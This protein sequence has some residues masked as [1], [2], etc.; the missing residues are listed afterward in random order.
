LR[1]RFSAVIQKLAFESPGLRDGDARV[2]Y[3]VGEPTLNQMRC[4]R[5]RIVYF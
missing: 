1:A 5:P 3:L 2:E 4:G